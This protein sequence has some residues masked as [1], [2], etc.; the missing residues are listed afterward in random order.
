MP[1]PYY[2]AND[3]YPDTLLL[4]NGTGQFTDGTKAA[5]LLAKQNRRTYSA[6]FADLD[7]DHDL[8]LLTVCDFSGIDL[9]RN[10]G[11]G[12]YTDVT[13]QWVK[14]RH[15][16]G[17]SH[18]VNDF[19]GDGAA[20]D[21]AAA[22]WGKGDDY[23][24]ASAASAELRRAPDGVRARRQGARGVVRGWRRRGGGS[25]PPD[26]RRHRRARG[27]GRRARERKPRPARRG[28]RGRRRGLARLARQLRL[29]GRRRR[30][31]VA[32]QPRQPRQPR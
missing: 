7:G 25:S 5:G 14:Q 21:F 30:A 9:Y 8:D 10:D 11:R 32:R 15:G 22:E 6:S 12:T 4:N 3:G 13:D 24:Y 1:T 31:R 23:Y 2:D 17:M 20:D 29:C 18:A 28:A 27:G 19:D 26:H 16:F